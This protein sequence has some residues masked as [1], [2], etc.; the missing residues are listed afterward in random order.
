MQPNERLEIINK[1][2]LEFQK[3]I[4]GTLSNPKDEAIANG[5]VAICIIDEAGGVHGRMFGNMRRNGN[6]LRSSIQKQ[7][8]FG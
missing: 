3:L 4:P 5:N 6:H 8:R 1:I 7:V 2:I